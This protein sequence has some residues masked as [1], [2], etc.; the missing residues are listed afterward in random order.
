MPG[1]AAL[2]PAGVFWFVWSSNH[3]VT[4]L[5]AWRNNKT[6]CIYYPSISG[7]QWFVLWHG[8]GGVSPLTLSWDSAASGSPVIM[9]PPPPLAPLWYRSPLPRP[10]PSPAP[11]L[12]Q[13]TSNFSMSYSFAFQLMSFTYARAPL[14]S[15]FML[16]LSSYYSTTIVLFAP[17][18]CFHISSLPLHLSTPPDLLSSFVVLFD[19]NVTSSHLI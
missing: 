18:T 8:H 2:K 12:A 19:S 9:D 5:W 17:Q 1:I 15:T 7:Q 11:E 4:V 16:L 3:S 13:Q 14:T 6:Q 10:P